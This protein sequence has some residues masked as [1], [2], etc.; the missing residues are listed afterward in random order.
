MESAETL[1][2]SPRSPIYY[3]TIKSRVVMCAEEAGVKVLT[4]CSATPEEGCSTVLMNLGAALVKDIEC[5]VVLVDANF[6]HP[7][8]HSS[9]N[10]TA[11]PGF[12]D[13]IQD[14]TDV[15]EATKESVISNLFVLTS[16]VTIENP[17]S[18]FESGRLKDMIEV[19]RKE[20]DWVIFDCAPTKYFPDSS[21]LTRQ[22]SGE[23]GVVLVVRAE[24]KHAE[25][26][27]QA[28]EDMERAGGKVLGAVLN[29][30][31]YIIPELVY[32]RL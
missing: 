17:M 13:V 4:L 1:A 3:Q 22:L 14:G 7:S 30:Q 29:R 15:L 23:M 9:F 10:L 19:L 5:R 27:A 26:A 25:I 24:H 16:G 11:K 8:L 28:K 31:R 20:F 6:R 21:V 32:R 2:V 18:V 12:S